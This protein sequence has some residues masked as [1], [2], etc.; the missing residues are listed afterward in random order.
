M[1]DD[2]FKIVNDIAIGLNDEFA[3]AVA[4][5]D[6]NYFPPNTFEDVSIIFLEDVA[7]ALP[8]E[9]FDED[10]LSIIFQDNWTGGSEE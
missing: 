10:E 8:D 4:E 3:N 1:N 6:V 7:E 5:P 2:I 9:E